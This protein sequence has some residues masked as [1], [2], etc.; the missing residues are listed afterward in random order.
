MVWQRGITEC[1]LNVEVTSF[2]VPSSNTDAI[3]LF[4][5]RGIFSI[6]LPWMGTGAPSRRGNLLLHL[7]PV[8]WLMMERLPGCGD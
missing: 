6:S 5:L 2:K 4:W 7:I 3:L 1:G 8:I